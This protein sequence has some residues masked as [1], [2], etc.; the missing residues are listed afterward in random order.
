MGSKGCDL[1]PIKNDGE[2]FNS[3]SVISESVLWRGDAS[4]EIGTVMVDISFIT[5]LALI[6]PSISL[7]ATLDIDSDLALLAIIGNNKAASTD[8]STNAK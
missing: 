3:M 8:V 4:K 2:S 5:K 7:L 1:T 6:V